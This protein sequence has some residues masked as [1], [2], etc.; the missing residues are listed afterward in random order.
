MKVLTMNIG[1]LLL[2]CIGALYQ[3]FRTDAWNFAM[4]LFLFAIILG[5]YFLV[6]VFKRK[7][8]PFLFIL[9]LLDITLL[10]TEVELHG[11]LFLLMLYFTMEVGRY[12]ST[13]FF[14]III[15]SLFLINSAIGIIISSYVP[16]IWITLFLL[17]SYLLIR[18]NELDKDYLQIRDTYES[19]LNDYRIQKRQS[20][21]NEHAARVEERNLIAREMHDS[22]GHKL[23]ALMMQ[24]EQYSIKENKEQY[25]ILKDMTEE[26]LEETRK[27]VRL[28]QVGESGGIASIIAL[29]K[30]LESE[31]NIHVHFTTKQGVLLVNLS[32]K[33]NAV[34]Y[35]SIQEG[36]TNAMKYG[37]SK[38]VH[39]TLGVSP[40]GNLT[41]EIRNPYIH[42][43][44]FHYGFGL[45]NMT[46]RIEEGQG[47]LEVLQLDGEFILQG[48]IPVGRGEK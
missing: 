5:F 45:D 35:R 47:K 8:I 9:I 17:I 24:I 34:L 28:L 1:I 14:R 37:S 36:I 21:H 20:Y 22:V 30:K 10:V 15:C 27:A 40:I 29:I 39:I 41:F 18:L 7:S 31:N 19:L 42:K 4:L 38:A 25:R 32:N 44:P 13:N 11:Y 6:P 26:C 12:V 48:N 43:H 33:Q 23:T 3:A 46:K 16:F 2:L